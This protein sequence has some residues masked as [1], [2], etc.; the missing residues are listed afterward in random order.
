MNIRTKKL[1]AW[2]CCLLASR[3]DRTP[4]SVRSSVSFSKDPQLDTSRPMDSNSSTSLNSN[5]IVRSEAAVGVFKSQ[6]M[7][8]CRCPSMSRTSRTVK[9]SRETNR[10]AGEGAF[11]QPE[12]PSRLT[13][14]CVS[15]GNDT[16]RRTKS[17]NV[18]MMGPDM[19]SEF[20]SFKWVT[21]V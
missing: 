18:R 15:E 11:F 16:R 2:S 4:P 17:E 21:D 1:E 13:R 8:S 5:Q 3:G 20:T 7:S 14:R 6:L 9:R 10:F 19:E 12:I